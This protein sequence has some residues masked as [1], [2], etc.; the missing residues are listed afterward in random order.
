MGLGQLHI[1]WTPPEVKRP[2]REAK[3][4]APISRRMSCM[5]LRPTTA[6]MEKVKGKG[7]VFPLQAWEGTW[8]SRRLRLRIFS[9]FDTMKVVKSSPLRTG[10]LYPQEISWYSFLEAESTPEHMVPSAASE[11]IPSDNTGNRSRGHP[12]KRSTLTTTLPQA[13]TTFMAGKEIDLETVVIHL[14]TYQLYTP[15]HFAK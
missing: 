12:T 13:P 15:C 7:K 2:P 11:K 10:R 5:Y 8:G 3:N 9:T 1:R 4:V 14:L 6:F